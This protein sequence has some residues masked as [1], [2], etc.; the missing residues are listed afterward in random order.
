MNF[1][2]IYLPSRRLSVP[3]GSAN[4]GGQP[5][6]SYQS[7]ILININPLKKMACQPQPSG[8]RLVE[9]TGVEPVSASQQNQ[10]TTCLVSKYT[11]NSISETKLSVWDGNVIQQHYYSIKSYAT[12]LSEGNTNLIKRIDTLLKSSSRIILRES[13]CVKE[14]S[15]CVI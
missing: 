5:S 4:Y 15:N 6:P 11:A 2:L 8:R 7:I 14:T 1:N 3:S 9:A 10:T 13:W 12:E